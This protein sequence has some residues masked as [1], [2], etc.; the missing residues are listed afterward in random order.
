MT[1]AALG[2]GDGAQKGRIVV[3]VHQQPQP[4]AEVANLRA[5]KEALPARHAVRDLRLAQGLLEH[6]GLVVGAVEDR[7]VL[8][9]DAHTT[10]G[11][12]RLHA[13]HRAFG[14]VLFA[15]ALDHAYRLAVAELAPELFLE[16]L[17][18]GRD[19]VVGGLQDVAGRAVVLFERDDLEL[20]IV[21][22]QALQV[23]DGGAAPAVD[24]L[25]V[26]TDRGEHRPRADQQPQQLVLLGVGVLVFVDQHVAQLLLPAGAN[27]VV[28]LQQQHRQ[29]DQVVEID[30]L[31]SV[32]AL[33]VL[34]HHARRDL[35]V[36]ALRGGFGL[37]RCEALV[38]P[39]ADGPLPAARELGV[40]GA[41]SIAQ[42]A[43]HIVAV[44]DRESGLETERLAVGAQQPHAQRV[45]CADHQ[46]L[47]GAR[48]DQR[49][50]ALAHLGRR[51]VGEG[52]RGNLF[53]QQAGV[54]V[55]LQQAR[56][57][58]RDDPGLARAGA[59]QHQARAAQMVHGLQ[60]GRVE[61][62]GSGGHGAAGG[63]QFERAD[64]ASALQRGPAAGRFSDPAGFNR[65]PAG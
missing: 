19:H 22:R 56:D 1:D 20:R 32:E 5:I 23:V 10:R 50:G 63:G 57:L 62:S 26:V 2:R 44:E 39:A 12:Q 60:L 35:V 47:G 29:A 9:L 7:K 6:L 4:G 13:R 42:D 3:L 55:V 27:V 14:L 17:R 25:V 65:R 38:L 54:I 51:L 8:P 36:G 48:T 45:K 52:D 28:A 34:A 59:G 58:V 53:G 21:L 49:L 64:D 40:G 33:L 15:V 46:F 30:R 11:V 37:L 18:V 16:D 41:A 24:A 43:E 61:G 31:V